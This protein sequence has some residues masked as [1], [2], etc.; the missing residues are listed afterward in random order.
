MNLHVSGKK[1]P[2]S[3]LRL[4]H[5]TGEPG[6]FKLPDYMQVCSL[7]LH[8]VVQKNPLVLSSEVSLILVLV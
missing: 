4:Q 5:C 8:L 7:V 6:G 2:T 3:R 1:T